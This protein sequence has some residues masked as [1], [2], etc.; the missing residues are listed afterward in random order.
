MKCYDADRRRVTE[1]EDVCPT[2]V[3]KMG[4]GGQYPDSD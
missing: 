4:T 2:L 3:A 1:S